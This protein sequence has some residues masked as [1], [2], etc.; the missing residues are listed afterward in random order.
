MG[1]FFKVAGILDPIRSTLAPDIWQSNKTLHPHI[2]DEIIKRAEALLDTLPNP[3]IYRLY[4]IGSIAGYQFNNTSDVDVNL[5]IPKDSITLEELVQLNVVRKASNGRVAQGTRHPINFL[6]QTINQEDLRFEDSPF[7]V[8]DV[9]ADTWLSSPG[10]PEDVRPP[11]VE[12]KEELPMARMKLKH[13]TQLAEK[14]LRSGNYAPV[15]YG[16]GVSRGNYNK[17][18][19]KQLIDFAKDIDERR[20]IDYQYGFGVPRMNYPNVVYKIIEGSKFGP[21]FEILKEKK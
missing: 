1:K 20:K 9:L 13:F 7:G 2:K 16:N 11:E 3:P 12:F 8:Y 4:I 14:Y 10:R 21:L 19:K 17:Q 18:I 15:D 6:I 5:I